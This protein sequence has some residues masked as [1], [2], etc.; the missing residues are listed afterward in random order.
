MLSLL[1]C[2]SGA[3]I[4]GPSD[5]GNDAQNDC[6]DSQDPADCEVH[7]KPPCLGQF[8][9]KAHPSKSLHSPS[10]IP[11]VSGMRRMGVPSPSRFPLACPIH[12][13]RMK[14]GKDAAFQRTPFLLDSWKEGRRTPFDQGNWQECIGN[15]LFCQGFSPRPLARIHPLR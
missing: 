7:L 15:I 1:G 11:K 6:R 13:G 9:K 4:I 12:T 8:P 2:S 3:C 14:G 5:E 10:P